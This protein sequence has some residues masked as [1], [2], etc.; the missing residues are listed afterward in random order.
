[1]MKTFPTVQKWLLGAGILVSAYS[2]AQAQNHNLHQCGIEFEDQYAV[3]ERMFENRLNRERLLERFAQRDAQNDTIYIPIQ[4]HLIAN[5]DGNGRAEMEGVFA[6]LCRIND[7]YAIQ[8][9]KFYLHGLPRFINN[10]I[11]YDNNDR[12]IV[13]YLMA[14]QKQEGAVNIF[15][16]NSINN[17]GGL[18]TTLGYYTSAYDVIYAIRS[19]MSY[20]NKTLSHEIG[21]FFTLAHPFFGW[22]GEDPYE[23]ING[24]GGQTP[25]GV[26]GQWVENVGRGDST[27]NCQIAADGFCDTKPD[28]NFGIFVFGCDFFTSSYYQTNGAIYDPTGAELLPSNA[29]DVSLIMSYFGDNCT[30]QF[31]PDQRDAVQLDVIAR[32]WD[33]IPTP[34]TVKVTGAPTL[35]YPLATSGTLYYQNVEFRWTA[36]PGATHYIFTICR[37]FSGQCLEVVSEQIVDGT[38]AWV[39]ALLP[40]QQ[41]TWS[42]KP[43]NLTDVCSNYPSNEETFTAGNWAVGTDNVINP[44]TSSRLMPNPVSRSQE[45]ILDVQAAGVSQATISISNALGQSVMSARKVQLN[46]GSNTFQIPVAQL[47]AGIYMVNIESDKYQTTHRLVVAE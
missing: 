36:A 20:D 6:N 34:S 30:N 29:S 4:Y 3:R 18:G 1:M 8:K 32:G 16:G 41:Y 45:A 27:E 12:N 40:N 22:D 35:E 17:M 47:A 24:N 37:T 2:S 23:I 9:I 26:G 42:V 46:G 38:S 21:H 33:D 43:F 19:Q 25:E 11:M 7:D 13:G 10:D 5:S 44:V 15:I 28:Y 14:M 31:T 39:N